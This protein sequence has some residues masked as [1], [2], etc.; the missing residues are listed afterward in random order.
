MHIIEDVHRALEAFEIFYRA[1]SAAI[2]RLADR[3][4]HRQ[5]VVGDG[6]S[7]RWGDVQSKGE[8]RECNLD[9]KKFLHIDLLKLCLKRKRDIAEFFPD[10]IVF[11][12]R[13]TCATRSWSKIS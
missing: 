1:H 13:K 10:K 8:G 5:L 9:R 11:F 12:M 3:N 6:E 2:E 7:G 4:G